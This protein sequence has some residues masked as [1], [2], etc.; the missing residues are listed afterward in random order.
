M[1]FIARFCLGMAIF[2][3]IAL[4]IPAYGA[5]QADPSDYDSPTQLYLPPF[6]CFPT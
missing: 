2:A 6:A 5:D 3:L 4:G 1:R